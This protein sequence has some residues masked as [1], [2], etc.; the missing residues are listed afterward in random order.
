MAAPSTRNHRLAEA[1]AERQ[2]TAVDVAARLQVDPRTVGRWIDDGGR[3]PRRE[4]RT[5]LARLVEVPAGLLWPDADHTPQAAAELVA[6]YPRRSAV[7]P[8]QIMTLLRDATEKV[9]VLALA[10]LWLWDTMPDFGATLATKAAAGVAVRCCL[11]DPTG[12]SARTRGEEEQI[13]SGLE[14]RCALS[15]TYARR[16]L[17]AV[18]GSLRVHDTTLYASV[19]RFDDDLL[20][21]WH[22]YGSPAADAPVLH[23]RLGA[24]AGMAQAVMDSFER[25]WASAQPA[26]G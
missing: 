12:T 5:E 13:G 2:L 1:L 14:H 26:A 23:L 6:V 3:I 25:V 22:L 11:G 7:P 8:G 21:N 19:L 17:G 20:V 24:P 4:F 16:W 10:A 15:L 18:D 9:D